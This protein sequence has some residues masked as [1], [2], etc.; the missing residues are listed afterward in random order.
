MPSTKPSLICWAITKGAGKSAGK[1]LNKLAKA[2]GP[3]VEDAKAKIGPFNEL[4]EVKAITEAKWLLT[5]VL[6]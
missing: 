3:P 4:A 2:L 5:E 6:L 1:T